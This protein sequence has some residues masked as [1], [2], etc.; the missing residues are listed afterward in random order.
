MQWIAQKRPSSWREKSSDG[1]YAISEHGRSSEYEAFHIEALWASPTRL[2]AAAT[3][4]D[5]HT[6]CEQHRAAQSAPTPA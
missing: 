3:L 2:G 1:Y 4:E 6:L 5:A